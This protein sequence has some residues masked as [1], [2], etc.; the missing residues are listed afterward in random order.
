[1]VPATPVPAIMPTAASDDDADRWTVGI[2]RC[3]VIA[4]GVISRRR[5]IRFIDGAPRQP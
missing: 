2:A 3:I 1:M 5:R 4:G